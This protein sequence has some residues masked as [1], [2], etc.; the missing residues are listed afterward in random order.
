M[1]NDDP[2][3]PEERR[4]DESSGKRGFQFIGME[5]TI[6][7]TAVIVFVIALIMILFFVLS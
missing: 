7:S 5:L 4:D 3:L 2:I 6:F 1:R